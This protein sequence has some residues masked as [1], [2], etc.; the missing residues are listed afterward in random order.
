MVSGL[1]NFWVN[2]AQAANNTSS[3]SHSNAQCT[4]FICVDKM[5]EGLL[6]PNTCRKRKYCQICASRQVYDL[7]LLVR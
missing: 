5:R 2:D 4:R 1:R 6:S 7:T 3:Y